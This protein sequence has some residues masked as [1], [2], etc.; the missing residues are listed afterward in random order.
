MV[1]NTV[2]IVLVA[3]VIVGLA[4]VLLYLNQRRRSRELQARFGPEYG[5]TLR[6]AGSARR[7]EALLEKRT[8][9]VAKLDIHPLSAEDRARFSEAW[10][11]LQRRF[12]DSPEKSVAEADGLVRDLMVARG[13]PM[14]DFERRAEDISVHYPHVVK[15]YRAARAV[16]ERSSAHEATTEELRQAVVYYRSLFEELLEVPEPA[17]RRIV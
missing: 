12:V 4:V 16:A 2:W 6:E 8:K 11:N 17:K 5:R 15:N 14:A 7:A 3:A 10:S 9:R 1:S 13:Y